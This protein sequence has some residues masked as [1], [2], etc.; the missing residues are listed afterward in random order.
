[1]ELITGY[2]GK[3]H[4][5]PADDAAKNKGTITG[6]NVV[7]DVDEKFA[8]EV[9]YNNTIRI[10]SGTAIFQGRIIR[11]RSN[12]YDELTIENGTQALIR[13]DLIVARYKYEDGIE[14]AELVVVKGTPGETGTDPEIY[15]DNNIDAGDTICDMP[16]YRVVINGLN[17]ES[18]TPLFSTI[19]GL[20]ALE[21]SVK[22]TIDALNTEL[23]K[24]QK[25]AL[26]PVGQILM[27][28]NNVNPGTYYSG[29]TWIA[30]G[31]G[32]VPVGVNSS[33]G[34][35]NTAE[36]TGGKK[37]VNLAHEHTVDRH[38]HST[39]SHALTVNEIPAHG[40]GFSGQ[41]STTGNHT[42]MYR[43]YYQMAQPSVGTDPG[44]QGVAANSDTD[45]NP[46]AHTKDNGEHSH[47]YSGTT[48]SVGGNAAHSHG[49]TGASA[50]GTSS[51]L[52]TQS[53]LQ[54]YI[55]CYMWKRTA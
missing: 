37:S 6:D 21:Q 31:S 30:W 48:S 42:H 32:R 26:P 1:M 54:P 16:L 38:V 40:H 45:A 7:L 22:E 36:K 39:G 53:V 3:Q 43:D 14:S 50:P 34:D 9:V 47:S 15:D 17:V 10:K 41:T 35:F 4:I 29:T 49:N 51:A 20:K 25:I 28:A 11:I 44:R 55:T 12:L 19:K 8:Y 52:G 33:D 46:G 13:N 5:Y 27:T 23:A 18:V 2:A 24:I